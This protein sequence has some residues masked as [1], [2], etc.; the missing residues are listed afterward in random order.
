MST[1][2]RLPDIFFLKAK[3]ALAQNL[4]RP[5]KFLLTSEALTEPDPT[6][7]RHLRKEK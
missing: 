7:K 3:I 6:L 4:S 1:R 2:E 5:G